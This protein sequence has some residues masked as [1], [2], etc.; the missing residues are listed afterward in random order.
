MLRTS[1]KCEHA[2]ALFLID[3]IDKSILLTKIIKRRN[4]ELANKEIG[5][6]LSAL[7]CFAWPTL[8]SASTD[9]MAVDIVNTLTYECLKPMRAL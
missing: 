5:F 3:L 1:E 8:S 9:K 6:T 2:P 7:T 4:Y